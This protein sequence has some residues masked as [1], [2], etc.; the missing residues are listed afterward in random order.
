[1]PICRN[2]SFS[3]CGV[4]S[5][6][7]RSFQGHLHPAI[8]K[9]SSFEPSDW[10]LFLTNQHFLAA[11][12]SI[13]SISFFPSELLL[14]SQVE[15]RFWLIHLSGPMTYEQF[16]KFDWT[17][18][19]SCCLNGQIKCPMSTWFVLSLSRL[20]ASHSAF[21]INISSPLYE[22]LARLTSPHQSLLSS[23]AA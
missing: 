21:H 9:R 8:M 4:H 12:L 16:V 3:D 17:L 19:V 10:S 15:W 6:G 2:S 13:F 23:L 20:G 7:R 11:L 14:Y 5:V 1:M 22:S 18:L